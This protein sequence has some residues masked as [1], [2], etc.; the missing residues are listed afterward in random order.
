MGGS[1][2]FLNIKEGVTQRYPLTRIAYG[3]GILLII[4]KLRA[5]HPHV[6]QPWYADYAGAEGFFSTSGTYEGPDGEETYMGI[7]P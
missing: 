1:F 7:T 3:I 4:S 5:V 2:H 6:T